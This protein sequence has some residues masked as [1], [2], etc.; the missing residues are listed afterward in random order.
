M[1]TDEL[2][3]RV[4]AIRWH[5]AIDLGHGVVTPAPPGSAARQRAL[6]WPDCRGKTVLDVGA[7][8]GWFSFEAE[9][10]GAA[11]VL[12]TDSWCWNG[13]GRGSDA[14]F[15][16][17][18]QVLASKVE[19]LEIDVFDLSPERVGVFDVVLFLGVL[20]HLRDAKTALARVASVTGEVLVVETAVD[21]IDRRE[22]SVAFYPNDE[23]E[24][25]STNWFAPNPA[26]LLAL[27]REAGFDRFALRWG[28]RSLPGRLRRRMVRAGLLPGVFGAHARRDRV[29]VLARRTT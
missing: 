21:H 5:H 23:L 11:R 19:A 12:A 26:A 25:D 7:W 9:R 2:Q 10:R 22:P 27:L 24:G 6:P 28:P 8:D 29:T 17:A 20:Y 3:R 1:E 4:D 18:H 16:L 13:P 15:R 14:G